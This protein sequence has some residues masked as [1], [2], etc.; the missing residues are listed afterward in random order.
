MKDKLTFQLCVFFYDSTMIIKEFKII[1]K[2]S[3]LTQ[4]Y[5]NNKLQF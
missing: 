1:E 3:L 4:K 2:Y 5:K